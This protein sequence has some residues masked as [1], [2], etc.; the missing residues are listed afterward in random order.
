MSWIATIGITLQRAGVQP[1]CC[2]STIVVG[3]VVLSTMVPTVVQA[4]ETPTDT[5]HVDTVHVDTV[6]P[7]VAPYRHLGSL[8]LA[9]SDATHLITKRERRTLQYQTMADMLIRALPYQALSHGGMGQHSSVSVL[10]GYN[11]DLTVALNGRPV[12]DPWS[13]SYNLMQSAPERFEQVEVLTG[14]NAIGLAP[15]MTLVAINQQ[16]IIHRTPTPYMQLWYAQGGGEVLAA[17]VEFSQNVAPGVNTTV[18]IRRTGGQGRYQR[19]DFDAWNA[20]IMVRAALS[21]EHHVS[22]SYHLVSLN[23]DLWGGLRSSLQT[24]Q[25]VSALAEST[26]PTVFRSLRDETRRHDITATYAYVPEGDSVALWTGQAYGSLAAIRRFTN[27]SEATVGRGTH[28]GLLLRTE[29]RWS[30]LHLR[31]GTGVD[32]TYAPAWSAAQALERVQP[33]IFAYTVIP[34]ASTNW[35][36]LASA[37]AQYTITSQQSA[38]QWAGGVGVQND[39][40]DGRRLSVELVRSERLPSPAEGLTLL[41]EHHLAALVTAKMVRPHWSL[42]AEAYAHD[43]TSPLQTIAVRDS[44]GDVT[45][46]QTLNAPNNLRQ[47][48]VI[49]DG[50]WNHTWLDLRSVVRVQSGTVQEFPAVSASLEAAVVYRPGTSLLRAGIRGMMQSA[51]TARA[52]VPLTWSYASQTETQGMVGNGLDAFIHARLGNADVRLSYENILQ[53]RWYTVAV[54]PEIIQDLRLSVTWAFLD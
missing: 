36:V 4:T 45:S 13:G 2:I 3:L 27:D 40:G 1:A 43:V 41:P 32:A 8:V 28:G 25:P 14:I 50:R 34:L 7:D 38:P 16:E 11:A 15:Q 39:A 33:Q 26:A 48:G 37:R 22:L 35:S 49:L 44:S 12:I 24:E 18:G 47:Y 53:S 21:I 23:T 52:Y 31:V 9:P 54:M 10:G 6:Q 19:T 5:L 20:S 29:Q 30:W 17:D 42:S 51:V 46:T